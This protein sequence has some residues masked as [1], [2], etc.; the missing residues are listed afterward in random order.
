M[1]CSRKHVIQGSQLQAIS[2][3]D[4]ITHKNCLLYQKLIRKYIGLR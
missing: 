1:N 4:F 2:G 3:L